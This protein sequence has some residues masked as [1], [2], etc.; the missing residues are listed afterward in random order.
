[1]LPFSILW[2][3]VAAVV[4]LL[5]MTRRAAGAPADRSEAQAKN[6]DSGRALACIAVVSTLAL[7]AGFVYVG[8]FLVSGL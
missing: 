6:S 8:R 3:T 4:T 5:A 7:L 1:M 2:V